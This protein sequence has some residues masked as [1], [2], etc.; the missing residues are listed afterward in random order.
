MTF[1]SDCLQNCTKL[2]ARTERM[3]CR[4]GRVSS[5]VSCEQRARDGWLRTA[6]P[7]RWPPTIRA[8]DGR[9]CGVVGREVSTARVSITVLGTFRV[10]RLE[11]CTQGYLGRDGCRIGRPGRALGSL[12][13]GMVVGAGAG[14]SQAALSGGL[15][16]SSIICISSVQ[17]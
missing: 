11:G 9:E 12:T 4:L 7:C 3:S 15:V 2:T 17:V 8:G 5:L 10:T 16:Q 1:T 6:G 13:G 14:W